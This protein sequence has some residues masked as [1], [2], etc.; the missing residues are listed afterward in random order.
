L[1]HMTTKGAGGFEDISRNLDLSETEIRD[2][3]KSNSL[4]KTIMVLQTGW[5]ILQCVSRIVERLPL[6]LLEIE[7]VVFAGLNIVKYVLWSNEPLDVAC[8]VK[9]NAD[10]S[11]QQVKG[12]EE[13]EAYLGD[14][15]KRIYQRKSVVHL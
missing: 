9:V 12:E 1:S 5:S 8:Q 14:Q 10:D 2:Q 7:T 15:L 4:A 6:T 3:S 11:G 13:P